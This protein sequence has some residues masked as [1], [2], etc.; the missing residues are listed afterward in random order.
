M[1]LEPQR[2]ASKSDS[3]V[4]FIIITNT[5]KSAV[6]TRISEHSTML[7]WRSFSYAWRTKR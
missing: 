7:D 4:C 6:A 3:F 5:S 1:S 2:F